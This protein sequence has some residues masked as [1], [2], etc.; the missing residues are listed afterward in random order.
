MDRVD[1]R[2][3]SKNEMPGIANEHQH[4][5]LPE[6]ERGFKSMTVSIHPLAPPPYSSAK[7]GRVQDR[8]ILWK[9]IHVSSDTE[10]EAFGASR[11]SM[12]AGVRF[13]YHR[14][15]PQHPY[16]TNNPSQGE[17]GKNPG[18]MQEPSVR[19]NIIMP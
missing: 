7:D 11:N 19:T 16:S 15:D 14:S 10:R 4:M 5:V 3:H 6:V 13:K 9:E 2:L 8:D 12:A 1:G 17:R 18:K